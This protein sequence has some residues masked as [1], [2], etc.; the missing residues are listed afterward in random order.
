MRWHT[1]KCLMNITVANGRKNMKK[2]TR[3]ISFISAVLLV[4]SAVLMTACGSNDDDDIKNSSSDLST[5]TS[6]SS[7]SSAP[8]T[9]SG[10]EGLKYELNRKGD[11]YKV[12]GIESTSDAENIIIPDTYEGLPVSTMSAFIFK[13]NI[14]IKSVTIGKNITKVNISAFQNCTALETVYIGEGVTSIGDNAFSGCVSLENVYFNDKGK[15]TGIDSYAFLGCL[16]LGTISIPDE[17]TTLGTNVFDGC[18]SLENVHLGA[19]IKQISD[20]TFNECKKLKTINIDEGITDIGLYAF[21]NCINLAKATG[22]LTIPSTVNT[23]DAYSFYGCSSIT[24]LKLP[25]KVIKVGD[26]AFAMTTS[27]ATIEGKIRFNTISSTNMGSKIFAGC[28]SLKSVVIACDI[29]SGAF[30]SVEVLKDDQTKETIRCES[31]T[32]VE[33]C[34][35]VSS[36][37]YDVFK[38]CINLDTLILP[39]SVKT[40]GNAFD[41]CTKLVIYYK[42]NAQ[43]FN[44]INDNWSKS[45]SLY[46]FGDALK[47]HKDWAD[48][49]QQWYPGWEEI[50]IGAP[51]YYYSETRPQTNKVFWSD[52][53]GVAYQTRVYGVTG[54]ISPKPNNTKWEDVKDWRLE[55][56][57]FWHY[58][59]VTGKPALW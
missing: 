42:G 52:N 46:F 49:G 31:L 53:N 8:P 39:T 22:V 7:S 47:I 13:D 2:H 29:G 38:N 57:A 34:D 56:G 43:Q 32:Y 11:A 27:L 30:S 9:D 21:S 14:K 15:L 33:I 25:D 4:L 16:A 45:S 35:G 19:G 59:V 1:E 37:T 24:T 12:C 28:K 36:I 20:Y 10:T 26:C 55:T 50:W 48:P 17:V 44:E 41:K 23:I 5:P 18:S 40:V 54:T 58:D 51:R 3:I 6:S